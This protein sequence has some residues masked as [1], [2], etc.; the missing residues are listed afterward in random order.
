MTKILV[1][2][3]DIKADSYSV[4]FAVN[5]KDEA[6]RSF[7]DALQ[8]KNTVLG[9]HP[10]DFILFVVGLF[11]EQSGELTAIEKERIALGSDYVYAVPV[12]S[13]ADAE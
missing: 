5:T 8:D 13:V 1:S 6:R 2:C 11:Y 4:P 7:G 3:Y 9:Q 12:V 10:A